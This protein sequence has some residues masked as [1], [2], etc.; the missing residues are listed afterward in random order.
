ML[1]KVKIA[2]R[3]NDSGI[4]SSHVSSKLAKEEKGV[5]T[6]LDISDRYTDSEDASDWL[7]GYMILKRTYGQ[8]E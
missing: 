3:P 4:K 8:N 2:I 1:L 5:V 7:P 6:P